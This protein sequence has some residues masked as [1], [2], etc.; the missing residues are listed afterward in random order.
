V[1]PWLQAA[2]APQDP[3][4]GEAY[5]ARTA[6]AAR[7]AIAQRLRR[8]ADPGPGVIATDGLWRRIERASDRTA[9]RHP[10]LSAILRRWRTQPADASGAW[11]QLLAVQRQP[12][13]AA[14]D[15]PAGTTHVPAFWEAGRAGATPAVR[16]VVSAARWARD[17]DLSTAS[18]QQHGP[19]TQV[20]A[21]RAAPAR[22]APVTPVA[23]AVS[24]PAGTAATPAVR[25]SPAEAGARRPVAAG[26]PAAAP[27]PESLPAVRV[28]RLPAPV[29]TLP[30]GAR[31]QPDE[32]A[33]QSRPS[34]LASPLG[35]GRPASEAG[36]G[37]GATPPLQVQREA[38]ERLDATRPE[39]PASAE[40]HLLAQAPG[41]PPDVSGSA[42]VARAAPVSSLPVAL[43]GSAPIA[44]AAPISSLPVALTGSAPIARAMPATGRPTPSA[45]AAATVRRTESSGSAAVVGAALDA[46]RPG[47]SAGAAKAL[48]RAESAGSAAQPTSGSE[49]SRSRAG[50]SVPTVTLMPAIQRTL[51]AGSAAA[52]LPDPLGQASATGRATPGADVSL[53]TGVA[54]AASPQPAPGVVVQRGEPIVQRRRG[55]GPP[56]LSFGHARQPTAG[57]DRPARAAAFTPLQPAGESAPAPDTAPIPDSALS[58]VSVQARRAVSQGATPG[59]EVRSGVEVVRALPPGGPGDAPIARAPARPT[60]GP[61]TMRWISRAA[62]GASPDEGSPAGQSPAQARAAAAPVQA[63]SPGAVL[64]PSSAG[65]L[66]AAP[67]ADR[68]ALLASRRATVAGSEAIARR[69]PLSGEA[70]I[71]RRTPALE[72][73]AALPTASI[74]VGDQPAS[75]A[76]PGGQGRAAPEAWPPLDLAPQLIAMSEAL[77]A[78][79]GRATAAL[80]GSGAGQLGP[81]PLPTTARVQRQAAGASKAAAPPAAPAAPPPAQQPEASTRSAPGSD[82]DLE[83]VASAVYN[84]LEQRLRIERERRG[85]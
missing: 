83:R 4:S 43:T 77:P 11:T 70:Q 9:G 30:P 51:R 68:P 22:P 41:P 6:S 56:L 14:L 71:L 74:S 65:Q 50:A 82:L 73:Q 12:L 63:G 57:Q 78:A 64:R 28:A 48:R 25:R 84:L 3:S 44:R 40:T 60:T 34:S 8:R 66:G 54:L 27:G 20:S 85:L 38:G 10:M 39:S 31:L 2:E 13:A 52:G 47:P 35:A 26:A 19:G 49:P 32:I 29:P 59:R 1:Q 16:P 81:G 37:A 45:G 58:S 79:G 24:P 46:G 5:D 69:L 33:A 72:L 7:Q 75:R 18:G 61:A 36:P 23:P 42:V 76:G 62:S 53:P 67:A 55:G 17:A 15:E 21:I 80:R